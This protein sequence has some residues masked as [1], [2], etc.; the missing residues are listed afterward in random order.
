[1]G[2]YLGQHLIRYCGCKQK[3]SSRYSTNQ[4]ISLLL[5]QTAFRFQPFLTF[6]RLCIPLAICLDQ[7]SESNRD[8]SRNSQ[9]SNHS[10]PSCTLTMPTSTALIQEL[11]TSAQNLNVMK[12]HPL[13]ESTSLFASSC[14]LVMVLLPPPHSSTNLLQQH[15]KPPS[16]FTSAHF[17]TR[18]SL[19]TMHLVVTRPAI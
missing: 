14:S 8:A 18:H 10:H 1:M 11:S 13:R 6:F 16:L 7:N 15:L 5:S 19:L 9:L 3:E 4:G 12:T 17:A 2:I